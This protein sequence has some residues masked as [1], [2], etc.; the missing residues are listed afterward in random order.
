MPIF[1][2]AFVTNAAFEAIRGLDVKLRNSLGASDPQALHARYQEIQKSLK[3]TTKAS[4]K[5]SGCRECSEMNTTDELQEVWRSMT[6][7]K[8][9]LSEGRDESLCT[10]AIHQRPKDFIYGQKTDR[11]TQNMSYLL[12]SCRT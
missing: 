2:S 6:D 1:L 4:G 12:L 9:S 8:I 10:C 3:S 11:A 7:F 5:R